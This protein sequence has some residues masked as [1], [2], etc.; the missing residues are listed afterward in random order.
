MSTGGDE[1]MGARRDEE[2]GQGDGRGLG[3]INGV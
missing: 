3:A 2:T 1:G